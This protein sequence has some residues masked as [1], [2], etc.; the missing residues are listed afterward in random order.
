MR[1]QS[2]LSDESMMAKLNITQICQDQLVNKNM[3]Q[4]FCSANNRKVA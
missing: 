2:H 1:G 3:E 4:L